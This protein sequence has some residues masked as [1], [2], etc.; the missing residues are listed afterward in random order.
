MKKIALV[1]LSALIASASVA[2]AQTIDLNSM[3]LGQF[4][5]VT[6][7]NPTSSIGEKLKKRVV[8]R[9]GRTI[10][11]YYNLDTEGKIVIVSESGN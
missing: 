2:G 7:M 5:T 8:V 11:Q 9:D 3:P 10:T 6:D 4:P 1:T